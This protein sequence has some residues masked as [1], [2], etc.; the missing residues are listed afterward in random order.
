[1]KPA[2][3][4]ESMP[5]KTLEP[6]RAPSAGDLPD[7]E[8]RRKLI[9]RT[10]ALLALALTLLYTA[11]FVSQHLW[12]PVALNVA[13]CIAL[14]AFSLL[15][16]RKIS[17]I[18]IGLFLVF[19]IA[20]LFVVTNLFL[21]KESG[22]HYFLFC[23]MPFLFIA[24]PHKKDLVFIVLIG[25]LDLIAFVITEYSSYNSLHLVQ[26]SPALLDLV[27]MGSTT[28]TI[29]L[30]SGLVLV[31]Y[32]DISKAKNALAQEHSRSESLL[33][34]VLPAPIADRLKASPDVIA[35]TF[36][37]A[38]VLFADIAGFTALAARLRPDEV[39]VLPEQ[40]LLEL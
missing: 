38:S 21:G 36:R 18:S 34:N 13:A 11:F 7:E 31:L 33:L 29:L 16:N 28:G 2:T 17:N 30:I 40:L 12:A 1:M 20:Q 23:I 9:V 14:A 15:L 6:E 24:F 4:L 26:P 35:E 19:L 10:G 22:I 3:G 32:L 25:I 39:V 27:H 8:S 5:I 37:E